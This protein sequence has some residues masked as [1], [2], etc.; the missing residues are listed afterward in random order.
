MPDIVN[1]AT[2]SRMMSGIRSGNT[3]PEIMIRKS[4]RACG[5]RYR[6]HVRDVPGTPDMVFPRRRA[7]VFVNGC[8]WHGHDCPLFRVPTT[9]TEFWAEKIE[10][11]RKRDF[12]VQ[13]ELKQAGW[14][15]LTIWECSI[16][17][18]KSIGLPR[19]VTAASSWLE[20]GDGNLDIRGVID[21]IS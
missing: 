9:R 2:R 18:R 14:R 17:G 20:T 3:K 10:H 1:S 5:F 21:G 11:N 7:V 16:R 8:F 15:A 4:L 6:L 13:Q 19:V 12:R